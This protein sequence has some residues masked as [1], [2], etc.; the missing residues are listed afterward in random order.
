MLK[1]NKICSLIITF[2]FYLLLFLVPLI[3]TPWNY[4]LFEFNKMLI[5]YFFALLIGASWLIKMILAKKFIFK[6]TFWDIPLIIFF[7]SQLISTIFS[8]D[9]HTSFWGYYSRF[10]GGLA[11]TISY[12]ILYWAFVNNF[13][14]KQALA[15]L[16][17]TLLSTLLVALYGIAEHFGI[18]AHK[19]VQDVRSRVF[20]TLGQPNWLAAWLVALIPIPMALALEKKSPLPLR[21]NLK[22]KSSYLKNYYFWFNVVLLLIFYLCLLY[23][24]SRSGLIAF[25]LIYLIFW[26]FKTWFAKKQLKKLI[27]PAVIITGLLFLITITA[28]TPWSKGLF[29]A[30]NKPQTQE[31]QIQV[32]NN[33]PTGGTESGEIR[34]IV[35]K[36]SLELWKHYPI[37][38]TGVETFAYSY[39]WFRPREHNDVSEW[40]F[41]YNKAHN[42]YLNYAA[43]SGTVGLLAHLLLIF[44]FVCWSLKQI[45]KDKTNQTI[46]LALLAGFISITITNFFGFSVVAI[47]LLF[48]LL[49]AIGVS[50]KEKTVEKEIKNVKNKKQINKI[51]FWQIITITITFLFTLYSIVF[52]WRWW[53]ADTRFAEAE[54]LSKTGFDGNAFI[55]I[56]KAVKTLPSEPV[57]LDS[58]SILAAN[59]ATLGYDQ[60]ETNNINQLTELA[61]QASSQSLASNPFN[62]NFWKNRT[63]V[64]YKLAEIDS[65]YNQ[66]ALNA[67]LEAAKLAPTDAKIQYNL[68][69]IYA[70]IGQQQE[71]IKTLEETIN[72]KPNYDQARYA[73]ALFYEK[74]DKID[75]AKEQLEYILEKIDPNNQTAIAKLKELQ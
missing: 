40:D 75:Q 53:Y 66:E 6:R 58:L 7:I 3:M 47:M 65:T 73:L 45:F 26:L 62:L 63:R 49:P 54:K 52:L 2:S 50:L 60:D 33:I 56:Q 35:W 64:F 25:G 11:S 12:L 36:G 51:N 21:L 15:T 24:K 32:A 28:G 20:S 72:L 41:L 55:E 4:E 29:Q 68:G 37:F 18:D 48:F 61:I 46:F 27:K 23:T 43:T 8:I 57:Y 9:R 19:W 30:K 5:V 10:N 13:E 22:N 67:L 59:L 71:A 69:I 1:I 31:E 17:I 70:K 74:E 42:E 38:G 14:R 39:Y 16:R 44:S 34:K